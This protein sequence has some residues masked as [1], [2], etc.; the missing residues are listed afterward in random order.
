M[1]A[2][3]FLAVCL[4]VAA[5]GPAAAQNPGEYAAVAA[6]SEGNLQV[7]WG[8]TAQEAKRLA[9]EACAK[10]SR[11]CANDPASTNLL[12]NTFAYVCC[13]RPNFSCAAPSNATREKAADTALAMMSR[14]GYSDCT[15]RAYVSARTGKPQ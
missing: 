13:Y 7:R 3:A 12:D 1:R 2:I 6:N 11:T 15:V 14:G 4:V 5:C 10:T 9:V 8:K